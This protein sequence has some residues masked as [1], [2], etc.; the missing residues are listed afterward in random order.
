MSASFCL[1]KKRFSSP[2]SLSPSGCPPSLQASVRP[3]ASVCPWEG[4]RGRKEEGRM[5]P[6]TD[7]LQQLEVLP[8]FQ[9]AAH[10]SVETA[11]LA[12]LLRVLCSFRRP[13]PG[14]GLSALSL[15]LVLLGKMFN[16]GRLN[17]KERT[18]GRTTD[19]DGQRDSAVASACLP[20]CVRVRG[21]PEGY[22]S[23]LAQIGGRTRLKVPSRRP[24]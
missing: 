19:A 6:P 23:K 24:I 10:K 5:P 8:S 12:Y 4:G 16:S 21:H 2:E 3:S 17:Q 9:S 18:D 14:K 22:W 1:L 20:A 11:D 7:V 13:R 15:S